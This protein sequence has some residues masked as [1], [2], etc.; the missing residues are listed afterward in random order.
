MPVRDDKPEL[1]ITQKLGNVPV[2]GICSACPHIIF[3]TGAKV[4]KSEDHQRRWKD[5][6][7]SISERYM[8]RESVSPVVA[9]IANAPP[10]RTNPAPLC[11]PKTGVK[12]GAVC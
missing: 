9:R 5:S 6:F 1:L 10:K 12:T 4:G 8:P 3:D 11:E 7:P 2:R